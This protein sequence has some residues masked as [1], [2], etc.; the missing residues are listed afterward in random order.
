MHLGDKAKFMAPLALAL[1]AGLAEAQPKEPAPADAPSAE[2][3]KL[4]QNCDARKFETVIDVTVEGKPRKSKVKLCG[5]AGQSDADWIKTLKE[6]VDKTAANQKMPQAMRDRIITALNGEI[7][8]L[9]GLQPKAGAAASAPP[10]PKPAL[11]PPRQA[12]QDTLA[13]DYGSLPPLP[14]T[15][16]PPTRVLASAGVNVPMLSRPRLSMT[17]FA[18][19]DLAGD[20]PCTGFERDTLLIVKAGENLPPGTSLRFVRNGDRQADVELAQ[21]KRGK[22]MRVALPREV[23]RGVVGGRLEIRIV[24]SVPAV[25]PKG[26]EVGKEGPYNLRC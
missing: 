20:G 3:Q 13:R 19:G 2:M 12:R 25:G 21:L 18:P 4:L 8:R 15:A 14:A 24:R 6:A 22:S 17:C 10:A 26:Q 23:C 16:P 7:A 5:T 9:T 1:V 11:P